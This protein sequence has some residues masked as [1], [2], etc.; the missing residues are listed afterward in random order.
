[1]LLPR[2]PADRRRLR[3]QLP[4]GLSAIYFYYDP[5]ERDRSLGTCNVLS[6]IA[7]GR[8]VGCRTST[9]GTSS[10]AAGRW[11]TRRGSG[12]TRC[13][14]QRKV[15]AVRRVMQYQRDPVPR[16]CRLSRT[17]ATKSLTRSIRVRVPRRQRPPPGSA[18]TSTFSDCPGPPV[19]SR[20][21]REQEAARATSARSRPAGSWN[22]APTCPAG[23]AQQE[24]HASGT[25]PPPRPTGSAPVS[26]ASRATAASRRQNVAAFRNPGDSACQQDRR[27][28]G[29]ATATAAGV[30]P[31]APGERPRPRPPTGPRPPAR[32]PG[33]PRS[34]RWASS[35]DGSSEPHGPLTVPRGRAKAAGTTNAA[36]T[37]AA[38]PRSRWPTPTATPGNRATS[39]TATASPNA[40]QAQCQGL[41]AGT[42]GNGARSQ[43]RS[44]RPP[45]RPRPPGPPPAG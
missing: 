20:S 29:A 14:K 21:P 42:H 23:P 10:R 16:T 40:H 39:S 31:P 36:I 43:S 34:C 19:V 3:R 33:Y 27:R 5:D 13:S 15:E 18:P 17:R 6:V 12:P 9:W 28:P 45:S 30:E 25:V 8:G 41:P 22:P 26:H 4:D 37:P 11:S 32:T 38:V 35:L 2:R 24:Q 7:G 1:M 44:C